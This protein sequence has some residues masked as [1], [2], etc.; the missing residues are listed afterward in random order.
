[1]LS[2]AALGYSGERIINSEQSKPGD[3]LVYDKASQKY[4]YVTSYSLPGV[5]AR[6]ISERR[7][8]ST[9]EGLEFPDIKFTNQEIEKAINTL[10]R[11]EPNPV[12]ITTQSVN[13]EIRFGIHFNEELLEKFVQYCTGMLGLIHVRMMEAW[14]YRKPNVNRGEAKWAVWLM[15]KELA[16]KF[17]HEAREKRRKL[18][19][20]KNKNQ[21]DKIKKGKEEE[22]KIYDEMIKS[23][24]NMINSEKFNEIREKYDT[25]YNIMMDRNCF[26]SFLEE[27]HMKE[28]V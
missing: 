2:G 21:K 17:F 16:T 23:H 3:V 20:N 28:K 4:I 6:D 22:I 26:P 5:S 12:L 18:N 25:F 9:N 11:M 8:N 10:Y 1:L 27:L 19:S 24:W 7:R 15:G 13:N 14:S